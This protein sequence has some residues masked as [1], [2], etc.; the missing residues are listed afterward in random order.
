MK[1]PFGQVVFSGGS[2]S[3]SLPIIHSSDET[4]T[5]AD[6]YVFGK[7][8][9]RTVNRDKCIEVS[10]TEYNR[11]NPIPYIKPTYKYMGFF[12]DLLQGVNS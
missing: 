8:Q 6:P 1:S 11:F 12:G 7:L 5:V 2:G 4:F 3:F 10:E 9:V